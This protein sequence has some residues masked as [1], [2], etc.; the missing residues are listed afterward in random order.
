MKDTKMKQTQI[1]H[2]RAWKEIENTPISQVI[3][4]KKRT[5]IITPEWHGHG[6]ELVLW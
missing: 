3:V 6:H 2:L 5:L 1:C 4:V